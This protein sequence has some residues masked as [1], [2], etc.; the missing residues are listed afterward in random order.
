MIIR[1]L[2]PKMLLLGALLLAA[3]AAASGIALVIANER[4]DQLSNARGAGRMVEVV[5]RLEAAGFRVDQATDLSAPALRAALAGLDETVRQTQPER[6]V[7][8]YAGFALHDPRDTWLMGTGTSQPARMTLDD[9][10]VRLELLLDIAAQA[11]GGGLV[12]LGD[13]GYPDR[14]PS[15]LQGGIGVA[16]AVP[17]GVTLVWGPDGQMST[18]LRDALTPGR[19]LTG[20]AARMRQVQ[21]SGFAPATLPFLPDG[22][23][24]ALDAD[25]RAWAAAQ[26]EDI[27]AAYEAYLADY[28]Q[29]QYAADART[30]LERLTNTPERIEEA[31]ALTRDERRAIQRDLTLLNHDPRGIDG[32]FG[33]GT[34]TAITRWQQTQGLAANGF[35]NREQVHQLAVQATR[36]A[37]ELEAEARERRLEEE[38]RDRAFWRDSGAGQ[39]EV[40]LQA[41]LARFPDGVFSGIA[42]DRLEEI[43]A[44]RRRLAEARDRTAWEVA[45]SEDTVQAY[46]RY[47]RDWP[48]GAFTDYA[49]ARIDALR[50]PQRPQPVDE[51]ARAQEAALRLPGFTLM[52]IEQR[53]DALGFEPGAVDGVIDDDTRRAIRRYQRASDLP[54]TGYLTQGLV[55]R[56]MAEGVLRMFE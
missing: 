1:F 27:A 48:E 14:L 23:S 20:V 29:G 30:A 13:H 34:R 2:G 44:E 54:A 31:L 21:L 15:G 25:R 17:Q 40:G 19:S 49:E 36:R 41:Y 6:V 8:V 56:L 4:Y 9:M 55:A 5:S 28:P 47:L 11:P 37:A 10:G 38:R 33:P 3:P 22:H 42:R 39:D 45:E 51:A 35:L 43:E 18:F 52:I 50:G 24:P 46:R 7:I 12:V 53:L 16:A 26:A 32:I